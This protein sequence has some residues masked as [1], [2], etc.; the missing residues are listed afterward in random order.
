M[1][2]ARM[3]A[4]QSLLLIAQQRVLLDALPGQPPEQTC[5]ANCQCFESVIRQLQPGKVSAQLSFRTIW[6]TVR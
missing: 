2:V 1:I 4:G 6:R 5:F 3:A